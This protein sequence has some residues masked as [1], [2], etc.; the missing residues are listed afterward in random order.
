MFIVCY[1]HWSE[2]PYSMPVEEKQ[3][4]SPISNKRCFLLTALKKA[5]SE[6]YS[7]HPEELN[8]LRNNLEARPEKLVG[9]SIEYSYGE[10][11]V[12]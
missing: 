8:A 9:L 12:G 7:V 5:I 2:I 10:N 4:G 1:L 11:E 6:V 3:Q